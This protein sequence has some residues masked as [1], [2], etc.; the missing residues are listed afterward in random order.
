MKKLR[1]KNLN[2]V[3]ISQTNI[4][5]TRNKIELLSETVL[6][7]ID[8]LIVSETKTDMSFTTS[9]FVIQGFAAPFRLDRTSTGGR[10]LV[11]V[12]DIPSKLLNISFVCSGIECLAIGIS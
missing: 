1:I 10:I 8:I 6:G 7:N 5:F 4:N 9:Q 3:I 11:Y 2:K 12:D